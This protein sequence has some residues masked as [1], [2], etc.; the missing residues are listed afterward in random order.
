MSLSSVLPTF[1]NR[2]SISDTRPVVKPG[3]INITMPRPPTMVEPQLNQV[4][5]R[6]SGTFE[7]ISPHAQMAIAAITNRM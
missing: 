6:I 7:S 1:G 2:A 3:T 4:M 5:A